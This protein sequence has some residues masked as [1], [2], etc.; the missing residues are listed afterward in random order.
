MANDPDLFLIKQKFIEHAKKHYQYDS[1]N[2]QVLKEITR[3][4]DEVAN[5]KGA[6]FNGRWILSIWGDI[7]IEDFYLPRWSILVFLLI[8]FILGLLL[9]LRNLYT[10]L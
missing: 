1:E 2:C 10:D 6:I 5:R 7:I 8:I 3:E 4:R 9:H